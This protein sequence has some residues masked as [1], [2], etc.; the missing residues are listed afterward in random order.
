M[1][2]CFVFEGGVPRGKRKELLNF[3][4][5]VNQSLF[6]FFSLRLA[7]VCHLCFVVLN[8]ALKEGNVSLPVKKIPRAH[9]G[10]GNLMRAMNP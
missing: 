10:W 7:F 2:Q 3:T 6:S 4:L 5:F 1:S 9:F 8:L